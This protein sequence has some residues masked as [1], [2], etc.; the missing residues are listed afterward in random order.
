MIVSALTNVDFVTPAPSLTLG[1]WRNGNHALGT[2]CCGL[3]QAG[4]FNVARGVRALCGR[5]EGLD[6]AS[7]WF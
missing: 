2:V 1:F 4:A 5:P 7:K 3:P 6:V